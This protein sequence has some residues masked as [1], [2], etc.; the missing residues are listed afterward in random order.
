[1]GDSERGDLR[2]DDE[3]TSEAAEKLHAEVETQIVQQSTEQPK[4]KNF[5]IGDSLDLPNGEKARYK[6]NIEAIRLVK[7]LEAEGRY[8]TEAEQAILS[9]YV[10]WGGLDKAFDQRKTDWANEYNE[11]K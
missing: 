2:R 7:H 4:G 3:L 6:A 9:K 10:G 11:L 1:V 5:V 8:A